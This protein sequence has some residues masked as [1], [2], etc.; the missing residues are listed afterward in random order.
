M[1][2]KLS[3]VVEKKGLMQVS[4]DLGYKSSNTI[5]F[6]LKTGVIPLKNIERVKQYIKDNK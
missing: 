6:W 3:K 1:L 2:K 5:Y 4:I